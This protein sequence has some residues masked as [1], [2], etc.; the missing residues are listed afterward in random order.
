MSATPSS[1]ASQ[2]AQAS[3]NN[4]RGRLLKI[5]GVGFGVAVTVGGTIGTGILRTP[6]IVAQQIPHASLFLGIWVLGGLYA[7]LGAFS[8][9]ELA[10]M[11]PRSGGFYVFSRRALGEYPG[12]IVGWTDWL[13]NGGTTAAVAMVIGEYS[14]VLW[15][16]LAGHQVIIGSAIVLMTM[17]LQW[18]GVRVGSGVQ[19]VMS[20]L[21][22]LA[23]AAFVAA[24]FVLPATH[25]VPAAAGGESTS[26]ITAF[27]AFF[28]ALQ[29]V[30]YTYDGWY[31]VIYFGEEV[32]DHGRNVP[33]SLFGGLAALAAIYLLV[34]IA[35]LHVIGVHGIAGQTLAM[36]AAAQAIFGP[37][38]DT[39]IRSLTIVS[40]LSAGNAFQ[41]NASRIPYAMSCDGLAFRSLQRVNQGG[42]PVVALF[43]SG[44]ASLL[45]M[46]TGTFE[47]L[48]AIL[49]F[50]FVANYTLAYLSVFVLRRREPETPRPYRT[51]GYPWTTGAALVCSL[52]FLVGAVASDTR[53]SL[54]AVATLAC[55]YV[56]YRVFKRIE[57][58][59]V[60]SSDRRAPSS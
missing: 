7:L 12:F 28:I 22:A 47:R 38:G 55:S 13:S 4:Q 60:P 52:A 39:I 5:L 58:R 46:L 1:P 21:Q 43:L 53:N 14:G 9:A 17:V 3:G 2:N 31:T 36:G 40:M 35:M 15:P 45:L 24:A 48:A 34:N 8:I 42:T 54:Y 44:I 20:S 16:R 18:R 26:A 56:V 50:F 41:L 25:A 57:R 30:I 23:F 10:A 27:A 6:G 29:S 51:W 49:A 37:R 59:E 19:N 32:R 11:I 33:R